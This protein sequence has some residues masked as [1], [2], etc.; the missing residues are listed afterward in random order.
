VSCADSMGSTGARVGSGDGR[1]EAKSG[2]APARWKLGAPPC[3]VRHQ[4]GCRGGGSK[5]STGETM[6]SCRPRET[7]LEVAAL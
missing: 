2:A 4:L 3:P 7:E 6:V 5:T 1:Q